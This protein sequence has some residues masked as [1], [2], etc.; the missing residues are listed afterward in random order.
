MAS[1]TSSAS[2]TT[3]TIIANSAA[4]SD[5]WQYFGYPGTINNTILTKQ[6]VICTLCYQ[7]MPYKNNTSNLF[8]HLEH[9]HIQQYRKL[10]KDNNNY[11]TES[12]SRQV[13]LYD[14]IE[15]STPLS[16]SSPRHKQLVEA[17][18][19]FIV[20]DLRPVAVVDGKGFT[21]L[22]KV[23]KP[24]FT[25]PSRTYF[26]QT[27]LPAHYVDVKKKVEALLSTTQYCSITT[28]I[29]TAKYQTRGYLSL[30]CHF[31]DNEW[32]LRSIV[33]TTVALT[34]DHN[35]DDISDTLSE[36]IDQWNITDKVVASTT[37]NASNIIKAMRNLSILNMPCVGHTLQL[38][39]LKSFDLAIVAKMLSRIR[40]IVGHFHRSEKAMR[41]LRDK[42]KQLGAPIHKLINDCVTR[43]GST[44][45]M[46][47]RFIEQ[48]HPICA[49]YLEDRDAR[50]FMPS[51]TEISAAEELVAIL[52]V[53]HRVTEIV[54]GE[55]YATIGIVQ[56]L[57]QKLLHHTLA[58][59]SSDKPLS[60][61]IKKAIQ[62]DLM[63][64]YQDDHITLLLNMALYLDPRFKGIQNLPENYKKE[65]IKQNL[66]MELSKLIEKEQ[67]S[68][69]HSE[70]E[71]IPTP[72][73]KKTK[74]S[75]FFEDVVGIADYSNQLSSD[76]IARD[77][78]R[79][80][81]AEEPVIR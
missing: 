8:S 69:C 49:V 67:A 46:L 53:F 37:N 26:S 61:R 52:E 60:K 11:F 34:T 78:I 58:E 44:Y 4:K 55:K 20:E 41:N 42:Q 7:D 16:R 6:R 70:A 17:V 23:A 75:S 79:K 54:S 48:Q 9:H 45:S 28:D 32:T 77:E 10:H 47:Q 40:K 62:E 73:T 39:V 65:D 76:D 13:T 18:G 57:L 59:S 29:W 38:S 21:K 24:H 51:D 68:G 3:R 27:V 35:G 74:L 36:L 14:S 5:V 56:P 50:Q 33:L 63:S 71:T 30:T 1:S 22:M 72:P 80:Y 19:A 66:T 43:W 15:K 12:N 25:I 81:E 64:R 31:I 2:A